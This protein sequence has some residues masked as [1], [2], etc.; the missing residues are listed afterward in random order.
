MTYSSLAEDANT[1]PPHT[2]ATLPDSVHPAKVTRP[3]TDSSAT[4][5]PWRRACREAHARV[6]SSG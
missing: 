4:A 6:T 2:L 3:D 1:A 5:P